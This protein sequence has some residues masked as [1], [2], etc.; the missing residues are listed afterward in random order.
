MT[1][2]L[3]R[4]PKTTAPS[5]V[6]RARRW[7]W[8]AALLVAMAAAAIV[9]VAVAAHVTRPATDTWTVYNEPN[10]NTR[11]GRVPANG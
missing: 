3:G 7:L 10:A 6:R 1:T 4:T 8:L 2:Q 5:S 9:G 11:E